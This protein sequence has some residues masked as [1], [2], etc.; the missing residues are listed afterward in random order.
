MENLHPQAAELIPMDRIT[1]VNPRIR[2]RKSFKQI[3]D[4]I[5]ELGLK[6]PITVAARTNEDG[7]SYDLVCGQ[8]LS[9]PN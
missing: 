7:L 4:N 3:V 1:I 6:R 5:A 9:L 8:G 2:N